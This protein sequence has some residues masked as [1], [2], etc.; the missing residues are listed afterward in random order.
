MAY[1]CGSCGYVQDYYGECSNCAHSAAMM[2]HHMEM[3]QNAKNISKD[4]REMLYGDNNCCGCNRDKRRIYLLFLSTIFAIGALVFYFGK[5]NDHYVNT[6][7]GLAFLSVFFFLCGVM[8]P[9]FALLQR[10]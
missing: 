2:N 6:S 9:D 4:C 3:L 1:K 10:C 8:C 7:V 5:L